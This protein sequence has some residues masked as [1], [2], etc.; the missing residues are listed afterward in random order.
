MDSDL[1]DATRQL[2]E[3]EEE[4]SHWVRARTAQYGKL[5]T[6]N[7]EKIIKGLHQENDPFE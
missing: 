5:D 6:H 3:E 4:R 7:R 2:P 1:P